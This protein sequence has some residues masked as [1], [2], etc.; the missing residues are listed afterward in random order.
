MMA[1]KTAFTLTRARFTN[2][3]SAD[4]ISLFYNHAKQLPEPLSTWANQVAGDTWI[5]LIRDSRQ[6]INQQWQQ[7]VYQEFQN[8]I[9]HRYPFD[10]NQQKEIAIADFN[11]FFSTQVF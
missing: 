4:P 5:M 9:A 1:V 10:T 3:N 2:D 11:R 8:T 7:T 6:Y